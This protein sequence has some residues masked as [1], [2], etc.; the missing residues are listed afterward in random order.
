MER[1]AA[2]AHG[3]RDYLTILRRR[4]WIFIVGIVVVPAAAVLFSMTQ[5]NVYQA[6]SEVLLNRTNLSNEVSGLG[7]DPT[8]Y[9]QPQRITGTQQQIARVPA[10]AQQTLD[11]LKLKDRTAND[12]LNKSK[13]S[14]SADSD[15]LTFKVSDGNKLLAEK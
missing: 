14:S 12:L 1:P 11:A 13:V 6:S 10:V 9:Q 2:H 3:L 7:P 15:I 5:R 4:K 8:Q